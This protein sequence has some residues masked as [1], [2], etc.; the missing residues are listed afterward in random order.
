MILIYLYQKVNI[1]TKINFL[2]LTRDYF[3][4]S[5]SNESKNWT[6]GG[7]Y[8]FPEKNMNKKKKLIHNWEIQKKAMPLAWGAINPVL[9]NNAMMY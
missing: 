3:E 9:L 4:N 1:Y 6:E 7:H 5:Y 2:Y 8:V